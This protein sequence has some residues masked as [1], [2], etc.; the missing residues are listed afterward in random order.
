MR[1]YLMIPI[2]LLLINNLILADNIKLSIEDA[3]TIGIENNKT[4]KISKKSIRESEKK[5]KI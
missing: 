2:A 5:Y 3:L 4:I 1:K